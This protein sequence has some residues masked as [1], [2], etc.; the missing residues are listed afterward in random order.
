MKFFEWLGETVSPES[1]GSVQVGREPPDSEPPKREPL[2]VVLIKFA[3]SVGLVALVLLPIYYYLIEPTIWNIVVT[4][5]CLVLYCVAGYFI[6][7]Q[8]D[9]SNLGVYGTIVDNPLSFSDDANRGLLWLQF[10]LLPGRFIAETIVYFTEP[11]FGRRKT[12]HSHFVMQPPNMILPSRLIK[13]FPTLGLCVLCIASA[14]VAYFT[15]SYGTQTATWRPTLAQVV[16]RSAHSHS[17]GPGQLKLHLEYVVDGETH[18]AVVRGYTAN[19]ETMIFVDPNDASRVSL[20]SGVSW[21]LF[22]SAVAV[23]LLSILG[24]LLMATLIIWPHLASD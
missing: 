11:I 2:G 14:L 20:K 12:G 1:I 18:R 16:S 24:A 22:I 19:A 8:P 10:V 5:A 15:W 4:L 21:P 13:A 17:R 7:P 3:T 23:C 6:H 9:E